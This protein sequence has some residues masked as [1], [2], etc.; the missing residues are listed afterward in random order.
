[1]PVHLDTH[2]PEIELT[3]GTTKSRIVEYLYHNDEFG[4]RPQEIQNALDIPAG[5]TTTTL[6]RL[7]D[8]GLVG[9]T[10]DS[11][12]YALDDNDE[13]RRYL[14]SVEQLD[15]MFGQH[16]TEADKGA[17]AEETVPTRET[18]DDVAE[19]E[20]AELEQEIRDDA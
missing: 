10:A 12:Y 15:R 9:K 16:R 13:V 3:P 19:A 2:I 1:M 8:A 17:V 4:F 6:T 5:T 11:Y 18:R 7:H 14:A 20:L